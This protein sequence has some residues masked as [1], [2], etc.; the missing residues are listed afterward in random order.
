MRAA[1]RPI[2]A[3]V[4]SLAAATASPVLAADGPEG[5]TLAS[6]LTWFGEVNSVAYSLRNAYFGSAAEQPRPGGDA[7]HAWLET[8]ARLGITF[9]LTDRISF[10]AGAAGLLTLAQDPFGLDGE[11][12]AI[13]ETANVAIRDL[14]LPGL[15]LTLGR[16]D[17]KIGDGF[18]IQDGYA[19][20]RAAVWS[21]PLTFWDAVRVDYHHGAFAG[22]AMVARLSSSLG[23]DGELYGVDVAWLPRTEPAADGDRA[24]APAQ[25][26]QETPGAEAEEEGEEDAPTTYVGLGWFARHDSGAGL[27]YAPGGDDDAQILA[28]RGSVPVG[29]LTLAGEIALQSGTRSG[30]DVG[31][32][33]W[34]A[35]IRWDLP[36]GRAPY[37]FASYLNH[38]GDDPATADDE[39]FFWPY[40]SGDDWSHYYLGELVGSTLLVNTDQRVLK[41][42][43]GVDVTDSLGLRVFYLDIRTDT[44]TYWEVPEGAGDALAT[45]WDAVVTWTPSDSL[46]AWLLVG[47]A[48]PG[49]AAKALYGDDSSTLLELGATWSF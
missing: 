29:P 1:R 14:G 2:L 43:G 15:D 26:G 6:R 25:D 31:G 18:L 16:Q 7:D 48:R 5:G 22:T 33:A 12:T 47:S 30:I 41:L 46:E 49:R 27:D 35:D 28:L 17:I 19:D 21:V 23:Q 38:S 37:L 39:S 42:E 24:D 32:E 40:F 45:E 13:V 20:R 11:A 9:D 34:H 3:L 8:A 4:C 44:G 36:L 10:N